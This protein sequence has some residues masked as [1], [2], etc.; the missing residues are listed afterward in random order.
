[1]TVSAQTL[2]QTLASAYRA[3]PKLEAE[4]ARLRAIDEEIARAKSGF[5]PRLSAEADAGIERS[6]TRPAASGDGRTS[7]RGYSIT[8]V[9][10]VFN[11]LRTLS[12]LQEAEAT[13][14]AGRETLRQVE[15]DVLLEA[16]TAYSDVLRDDATVR[17]REKNVTV[18]SRELNAAR[19]RRAVG[20]VTQTDVAQATA[21]RAGAV[22]AL[23]VARANLRASRAAFERVVGSPPGRLQQPA[24]PRKL[25]PRSLEET[26]EIARAENPANGAARFRELA[27]RHAVDRIR[28][29]LLPSIDI[30]AGYDKRYD[31]STVTDER[32]TGTIQGRL[33][34]PLYQGG[35][36]HARVRQSKHSHVSRLQEI[37]QTQAETQAAVIA[38]WSKLSALQSQVLSDETQVEANSTALQGVRDEERVGQRTLLDVLNAE[39]ELLNSEV[40]LASTRRD[41]T[42][43]AY[44]LIAAVGRLNAESLGTSPVIYDPT[45][46]TEQVRRNWFGLTIQ[47]EDGRIE[48]LRAVP[49]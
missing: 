32:E 17:L 37:A 27:S 15:G 14:R 26:I 21:R 46:N 2:E 10:P 35:E 30:V 34:V 38:S 39:Q 49:R 33:S 41:L 13:V 42:V 40:A 24:L 9:Q 7:P 1:M 44:Q 36:V 45:L 29:E 19:E 31:T 6:T 4:R 20:E 12:Q 25:L 18:L 11:G 16:V 23:D 5:R 28:G 22:S 48:A 3:N 8:A 43:L 47:H